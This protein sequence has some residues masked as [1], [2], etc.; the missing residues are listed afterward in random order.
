MPYQAACNLAMEAGL[1]ALMDRVQAKGAQMKFDSLDTYLGSADTLPKKGPVAVIL[2]EDGVEVDTTV[3]HHQQAGFRDVVVFMPDDFALARDLMED[4]AQVAY[5]TA[6]PDALTDAVNSMIRA[7]HAVDGVGQRIGPG[8]VVG[9]LRH[10]LHEVAGQRKVVRHEH[11]DV[12]EPGLLVVAHGRVHF[13]PV[14]GQ[15]H[16]HRPL[17][18][19]RVRRS[20][21]CVE[22]VELHLCAFCLHSVH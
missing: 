17:F 4:V 15:D 5:D 11:H 1:T 6:R 20:E 9:H 22:T 21:V 2:A 14:F 7:D 3:R 16:R 13:H 19:Q 8:G 12:P 18:R 10:V